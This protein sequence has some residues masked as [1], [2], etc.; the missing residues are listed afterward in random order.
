MVC[1]FA[2]GHLL[3][4][5]IHLP[6]K[7]RIMQKIQQKDEWNLFLRT[8]PS[9]L[10]RCSK[11][12]QA[13]EHRMEEM[14][15]LVFFSH[16]LEMIPVNNMWLQRLSRWQFDHNKLTNPNT[17][18][19]ADFDRVSVTFMKIIPTRPLCTG[20][21]PSA[22]QSLPSD[23]SGSMSWSIPSFQFLPATNQSNN[24]AVGSV[25]PSIDHT[26][27]AASPNRYDY[28]D[29]NAQDSSQAFPQPVSSGIFLPPAASNG[30]TI[31]C[32]RLSAPTQREAVESSPAFPPLP[33]PGRSSNGHADKVFRLLEASVLPLES[34]LIINVE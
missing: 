30:F 10:S 33:L 34:V 31:Q 13:I 12:G 5:A 22:Y 7:Q 9:S 19:R 2:A 25:Y 14:L 3:Q 6:L 17:R 24:A 32:G 16:L 21:L 4:Q 28:V 27:H 1:S 8:V 15:H 29:Q 11:Q 20:Y 26:A 18:N 23:A